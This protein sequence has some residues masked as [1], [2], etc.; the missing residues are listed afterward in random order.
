MTQLNMLRTAAG[1]KDMD[2]FRSVMQRRMT[3]YK[4]QEVCAITTRRRPTRC[5][6]ILKTSGSI[7]WICQRM[8]QARQKIV[9]FELEH[10]EQGKSYCIIL[11]D[12][13][14]V[15]TDPRK[16][17]PVQGWRYLK[18]DDAPRDLG[19]SDGEAQDV[20]I[21]DLPPKMIKE[22]KKLGLL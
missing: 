12:P 20:D 3:S 9:G 14:I 11:L 7:Y 4:G 2:H 13:Q 22:L 8:I 5:D 18:G 19:G 10:D 6:E 21:S 16:K 17:K 1:I 15:L